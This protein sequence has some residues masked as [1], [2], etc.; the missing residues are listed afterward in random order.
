MLLGNVK[1]T[2][3]IA[4]HLERRDQA[5]RHPRRVGIHLGQLP[6]Q[7]HGPLGLPRRIGR[8]SQLLQRAHKGLA[9]PSPLRLHPALELG[10]VTEEEP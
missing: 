2:S 6:P 8:Q 3:A 5:H 4:R 1:R 10:T 9:Q 7:R